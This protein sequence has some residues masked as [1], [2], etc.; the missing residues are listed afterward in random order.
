MFTD[1]IYNYL[2]LIYNT[3]KPKDSNVSKSGFHSKTLYMEFVQ[4]NK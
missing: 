2:R 1:M 4:K 3:Y